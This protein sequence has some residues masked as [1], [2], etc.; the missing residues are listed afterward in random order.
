MATCTP[1]SPELTKR[2]GSLFG[3]LLHA[4][5]FRPEIMPHLQLCGGC[6]TFSTEDLSGRRRA[7]GAPALVS[8]R[9]LR[10]DSD[11]IAS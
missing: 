1:A 11:I 8:P 5:K 3:A 4:A 2:Y 7:G 6:L 9:T 10:C